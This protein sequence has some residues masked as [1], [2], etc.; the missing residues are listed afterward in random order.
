MMTAVTEII[1]EF[2]QD[3]VTATLERIVLEAKEILNS[4]STN[5]VST[6]AA[7][8]AVEKMKSLERELDKLMASNPSRSEEIQEVQL[9]IKR[10]RE[11][12]AHTIVGAIGL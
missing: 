7:V 2:A 8:E 10:S 5:D 6:D 4:V 12:I 9:K 1:K 3:K 11:K